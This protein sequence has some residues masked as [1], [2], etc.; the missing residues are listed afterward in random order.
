[1]RKA[2]SVLSFLRRITLASI[3]MAEI[4]WLLAQ[5]VGGNDSGGAFVRVFAGTIVGAALYFGLLILL[6]APELGALRERLR[7]NDA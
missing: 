2:D 3:L 4:V 5:A 7:R 1:M 6:G